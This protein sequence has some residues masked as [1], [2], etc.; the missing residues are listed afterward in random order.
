MGLL[1]K[2]LWGSVVHGAGDEE[3]GVVNHVRVAE[4]VQKFS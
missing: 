3:D 2:L 4:I 1:D